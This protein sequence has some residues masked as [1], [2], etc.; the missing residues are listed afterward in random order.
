M[1]D[2][3]IRPIHILLIHDSMIEASHLARH[4]TGLV[5]FVVT[6][7]RSSDVLTENLRRQVSKYDLV[8]VD[9]RNM[10]AKDGRRLA[11]QIVHQNPFL[12]VVLLT[13]TQGQTGQPDW[14]TQ[15][16][17]QCYE[18]GSGTTVDHII[19]VLRRAARQRNVHWQHCLQQISAAVQ[20]MDRDDRD[21]LRV[22]AERL[23]HLGYTD[24]SIYR[25]LLG[26]MVREPFEGSLRAIKQHSFL[27]CA[28]PEQPA[29]QM[30]MIDSSQH[31]R[32]HQVL[33]DSHDPLTTFQ[34]EKQSQQIVIPLR[35]YTWFDESKRRLLGVIILRKLPPH[36]MSLQERGNLEAMGQ[37][38]SQAMLRAIAERQLLYR[39]QAEEHLRHTQQQIL[40]LKPEERTTDH[41]LDLFAHAIAESLQFERVAI[42][43]VV[44][45]PDP[46][47]PLYQDRLRV[48]AIRLPPNEATEER[49][50]QIHTKQLVLAE[51]QQ[52]HHE[53]F[54]QHGSYFIPQG[55]YDAASYG[56]WIKEEA[57]SEDLLPWDWHNQDLLRTPI[58][59]AENE[60]LGFIS[61][62]ARRNRRRPDENTFQ[63]LLDFSLEVAI[64]IEN[65]RQ[66]REA[67]TFKTI[68]RL[69]S[70]FSEAG[71]HEELF[72][73]IGYELRRHMGFETLMIGRYYRE[74]DQEGGEVEV[75]Y[76]DNDN[77]IER[78]LPTKRTDLAGLTGFIVRNCPP[79]LLF[80]DAGEID[81]FYA[82]HPEIRPLGSPTQSWLGM[83]LVVDKSVIG[84]L[85]IQHFHEPNRYTR[86]HERL[87]RAL[88]G[89]IASAYRRV[90]LEEEYRD[91]ESR[92]AL[93]LASSVSNK[94]TI[95]LELLKEACRLSG[96]DYGILLHYEHNRRR[97]VLGETYTRGPEFD[98]DIDNFEVLPLDSPGRCGLSGIVA[99]SR[100]PK[101]W[102][103]VSTAE[104]Y[105][106][107]RTATRSQMSF[108][109]L[110]S[111]QKDLTS[112]DGL[113]L[114][115]VLT[116]ESVHSHAFTRAHEERLANL[117]QFAALAL[118]RSADQAENMNLLAWGLYDLS[119]KI[120]GHEHKHELRQL[121]L[122]LSNLSSEQRALT[123]QV[124]SF[125]GNVTVSSY[126]HARELDKLNAVDLQETIVQFT[127]EYEQYSLEHEIEL[128][129]DFNLS[130]NDWIMASRTG[131]SLILYRLVD[132]AYA[133]LEDRP[134]GTV[135]I[136]AETDPDGVALTIAAFS[137]IAEGS[138]VQ[139]PPYTTL[140]ERSELAWLV[141]LFEASFHVLQESEEG[142][143]VRI[144]FP[145]AK[146]HRYRDTAADVPQIILA[147]HRLTEHQRRQGQHL[148]TT[149]KSRLLMTQARTQARQLNER[150][151]CISGHIERA[152][153][154]VD[155]IQRRGPG[156]D[157]RQAEPLSIQ[158]EIERFI[159][160]RTELKH[161]YPLELVGAPLPPS[162]LVL[163]NPSGLRHVLNILVTNAL[164]AI[165]ASKASRGDNPDSQEPTIRISLAQEGQ[166]ESPAVAIRVHNTGSHIRPDLERLLFSPYLAKTD[167][168]GRGLYMA[169]LLLEHYDGSIDLKRNDLVDGVTFEIVLKT[170]PRK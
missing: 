155:D 112:P 53:Q 58:L 121:W 100:R 150:L 118:L 27:S 163:A 40:K 99:K 162:I 145:R 89:P 128:R 101:R 44:T 129:A 77:V 66:Q 82:A 45:K 166:D 18:L 102:D 159:K 148:L 5:D 87:L 142:R 122:Q 146:N 120:I 160:V 111:D 140:L 21:V 20:H 152:I 42:T 43:T 2:P 79:A 108:P 125:L 14:A 137:A 97:L 62:D 105:I 116:L 15:Y 9:G 60:V 65:I 64:A 68:E 26:W 16:P 147:R 61:A 29:E 4:I 71:S 164:H 138:T 73:K 75:V 107:S 55:A 33:F 35:G 6:P 34:D 51:F 119:S 123:E 157:L 113:R 52:V 24:V 151:G 74:P 136:G 23:E 168:G 25:H 135:V 96:A 84:V 144:V 80:R 126:E 48:R 106:A 12:P 132:D 161:D 167:G 154:Q 92:F 104:G 98:P 63:A 72:T 59:N 109:L 165:K 76:R 94:K 36:S 11:D 143:V 46:V 139:T 91:I 110:V 41:V 1:S 49:Q 10:P 115:G 103:D 30:K 38:I 149:Y 3:Y 83:P 156:A 31:P 93:K 117:C 114:L 95:E 17:Y 88:A 133:L 169:K 85:A 37:Q 81:K 78:D 127:A 153:H 54:K 47:P 50:H 8:L 39:R 170:Y 28:Y 67:E 134:Y 70:A 158:E 7:S 22:C 56:A 124:H 69:S 90:E 141:P 57:P 13:P 131:L 86:H 32:L 19:P 130:D